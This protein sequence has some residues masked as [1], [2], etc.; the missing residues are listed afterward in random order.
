MRFARIRGEPAKRARN[1]WS[2]FIAA[3]DFRESWSPAIFV[4]K[5]FPE[6]VFCRARLCGQ[7]SWQM[8]QPNIRLVLWI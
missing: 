5:F 6:T 2:V 8:S 7:A 1:C 3:R 4:V